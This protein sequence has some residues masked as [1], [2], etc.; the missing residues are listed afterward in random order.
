MN[1][2]WLS[3]EERFGEMSAREKLLIALCGLV[4]VIM[5]LFTL[6]LEPKL[7][8]IISNERQLSNLKQANQ[9]IEIDTLR[10]QAQLKKDPN[11]EIDRA[12]SNLLTESQHLSMQLAE[13]IEHLITPSQ[14]AELLENVLEQQSGIHLLSL[15]TLPSEPITE[16]K[17]ASQYSGYYVHPVRM[18]L[19]GDYFSIANYLNKLE[20]LP[21]SYYWRS[22]SYKV[23]EYPKAKLVLEVYTLGSREEFIGG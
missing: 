8:E 20:S 18:E 22:F 17:E 5:L 3:L 12:I 15:Q 10:I 7:N 16:D 2:F 4:V 21:A 1:E 19:T 13:I 11:A 23:E 6:V 9:K 14:M